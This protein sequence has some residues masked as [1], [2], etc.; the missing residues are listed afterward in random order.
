[1]DN[2]QKNAERI[3]KNLKILEMP[4][5]KICFAQLN[6]HIFIAAFLIIFGCEIF[7]VRKMC[8]RIVKFCLL[9]VA[10]VAKFELNEQKLA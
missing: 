5:S 6:S 4:D 3:R 10:C 9:K 1:M 8:L 7:F 2:R